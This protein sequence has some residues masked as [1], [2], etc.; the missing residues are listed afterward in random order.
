MLTE[1]VLEAN[2]FLKII[3]KDFFL[4][5]FLE[6][7]AYPT[8]SVGLWLPPLKHKNDHLLTKDKR[9]P[10]SNRITYVL[11]SDCFLRIPGWWYLELAIFR[12]GIPLIFQWLLLLLNTKF[13][14]GNKCFG[15]Y[16]QESDSG[17]STNRVVMLVTWVVIE[18]VVVTLMWSFK[19]RL[20]CR[21]SRPLVYT[22]ININ[23]TWLNHVISM[24]S[25]EV[26]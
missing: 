3:I 26:S 2:G 13:L 22:Y 25:G 16:S 14:Q 5:I 7:W 12:L 21:L 17:L 4:Y 8:A 18:I 6:S 20:I 23:I 24:I 19:R 9:N 1:S 15:E 11:L 10:L